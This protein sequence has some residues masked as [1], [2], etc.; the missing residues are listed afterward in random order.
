[1][2]VTSLNEAGKTDTKPAIW[3][4]FFWRRARLS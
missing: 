1:M 2:S 3:I 4:C